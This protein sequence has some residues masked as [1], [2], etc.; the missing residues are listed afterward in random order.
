LTGRERVLEIGPG[1]GALTT[2]LANGAAELWLI[3]IDRDLIQLLRE[4]FAARPEIHLIEGDVLNID[5]EGLLGSAA[6]AIVVANL[7]YNVSTPVLMRLLQTPELFVRL[8]LMVQ[9][10]VAARLA[11][12]PG[13]KDYGALSVMTQL[14]A[15]VRLALSVGPAAFSPRPKVESSVV[16]IEPLRPAPLSAA[17][18]AAVRRVVR[19]AFG[20]R[21]KQLANALSPL[22]PSAAET[23]RRIGIDPRRRAETLATDEF[24]RLTRALAI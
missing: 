16:V 23:L 8:V 24:V 12:K 3:E 21:R 22:S 18:L 15:N 10:E 13:T 19:A 17:E 5:L 4:Q 2:L 9:R 7:P 1:R 11:A 14:V 20:Q 6:P